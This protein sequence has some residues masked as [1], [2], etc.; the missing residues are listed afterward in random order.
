MSKTR[1]KYRPLGARVRQLRA[2]GNM[3]LAGL[4][5]RSGISV[6]T[7]SKLENGQTGLHLDNVI[8][9]AA[10]FEM[11]VSMLINDVVPASGTASVARAGGPYSHIVDSL[12]FQVLHDDLPT[13]QNIFWKVRL[14]AHTLAD[15]GPYHSHPGEEFFFVLEGRV[16]F[17]IEDRKPTILKVGDSVQFD[18]SL[19]H[20]Y[21]SYVGMDAM[22]LMSN[23]IADQKEPGNIDWNAAGE[24]TKQDV[25]AAPGRRSARER[26][27]LSSTSGRKQQP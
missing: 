10:A 22:I 15:F 14:R 4:S 26:R 21:L 20:A 6:S 23:T 24:T 3:T 1:R 11:P 18:S 19:D 7:L 13:Q 17:L 25:A 8:R 27:S 5:E 12:D 16:K 9:L 2:D